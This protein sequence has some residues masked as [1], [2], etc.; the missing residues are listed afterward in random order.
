[1][2]CFLDLTPCRPSWGL[3]VEEVL[4][5]SVIKTGEPTVRVW[6]NDE[7]VVVGR[8]QCVHAEVDYSGAQFYGVPVVRRL[9]GGGT[10]LHYP[11]NLNVSV[12]C[13]SA[14]SS[15]VPEV[16][17]RFGGPLA[18]ALSE[19]GRGLRSVDH[20]IYGEGLKVGGAAQVRRSSALLYHSTLMLEPTRL[21]MDSLL[22]ALQP[23]Y[24]TTRVASR[25]QRITDLSAFLGHTIC[26]SMTAEAALGAMVRAL[27]FAG[28]SVG[29]LT[30]E[31]LL[32]AHE[33]QRE[34]YE[35]PSWNIG[36]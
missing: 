8:S 19:P 18:A 33:L 22:R 13:S 32:R 21:P 4:F 23:G 29:R 20:G 27:G 11:G 26:P 14:T 31:E 35:A 7:A 10:V 1:M 28:G 16:F 9:S 15:D 12:F 24:T 36:R 34:K 2:R 3:A 6:V 25:P 17:H 5:E 30:D